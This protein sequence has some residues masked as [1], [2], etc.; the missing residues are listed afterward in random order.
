MLP[1]PQAIAAA[2]GGKARGD[3]VNIPT[4]GHSKRDRGTSITIDP[5]APDGC[6]VHVYNDGP[7]ALAVKDMLRRDGFLPERDSRHSGDYNLASPVFKAPR[8]PGVSYFEY[9]DAT[10]TVVCRK[11]R[12][13]R[14][15]GS[16]KAFAW[17]HPDGQGG[18]LNTR[19]CD[20]LVYRLPELLGAPADAVIYAAEGERKA[21]KLASWGLVAISSKDLPDDLSLLAGRTVVIL[22]D[23]DA[24]GRRI[25][26]KMR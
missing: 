23:N 3:N 24:E 26:G 11:V 20:P 2:Y 12:T 5:S 14:A 8:T 25:A 7:D 18:W 4:Q 16:D 17:Q 19:G 22:P 9:R 10:G 21:D 1:D 13:D 15:D 6:L